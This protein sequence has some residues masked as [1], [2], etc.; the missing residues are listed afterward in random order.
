MIKYDEYDQLQLSDQQLDATNPNEYVSF[1]H[2]INEKNEGIYCKLDYYSCMFYNKTI[3]EV[4]EWL[5]LRENFSNEFFKNEIFR[6]A[7]LSG[8]TLVLIYNA[9]KIEVNAMYIPNTC[10]IDYFDIVIPALRLDI[11]AKGLD[12]LRSTGFDVDELFRDENYRFPKEFQK[13]TRIDFAFDFVN[14]KG[15][16]LQQLF[17]YV[18]TNHTE[19]DRLVMKGASS[20]VYSK[21]TGSESTLY[22]GSPKSLQLFRI[23]DKRK[24]NVDPLTG[25]Y[26]KD[27]PY[28]SADSWIRFELQCRYNTASKLAYGNGDFMSILHFIHDYYNF[29]DLSTP[30]HRRQVAQFWQD[31]MDWT[32]IPSIIQNLHF[33]E[34]KR[35]IYER[36]TNSRHTL[37]ASLPLFTCLHGIGSLLYY[38][39]YKLHCMQYWQDQRYPEVWKRRWDTFL[40][41]INSLHI[42]VNTDPYLHKDEKGDLIYTIPMSE[43][44]EF[45]NNRS[46]YDFSK[47]P[48]NLDMFD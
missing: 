31:F 48:F 30:A 47:D 38:I 27:N 7:G 40:N 45:E 29:A 23:Y 19:A 16:I 41:K 28:N 35:P 18:D 11:S 15:D 10:S 26:T 24:Q 22:I 42:D 2:L 1:D 6:G 32:L 39:N 21:K 43:I 13:L 8:T 37:G 5:D 46:S 12:F 33:T 44:Y 4:L 36:V 25:L 34:P 17:D 3:N 14:Y 9:V 20:M